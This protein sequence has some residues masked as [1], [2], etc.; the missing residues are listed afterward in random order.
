[1]HGQTAATIAAP[2]IALFVGA[3]LDRWYER[4]Q[5]LVVYLTN[6][7]EFVIRLT[8]PPAQNMDCSTLSL[9]LRNA[10][11]RATENVRIGHHWLPPNVAINP[12]IPHRIDDSPPGTAVEVQID[13]MV[14]GQQVTISYLVCGTRSP[15]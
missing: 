4:R 10:G 11:R 15:G 9:V 5:R 12:S 3:A 6:M 14:P 8:G 2:I 1:M 13:R 7:A